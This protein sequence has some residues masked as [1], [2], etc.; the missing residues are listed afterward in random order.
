MTDDSTSERAPSEGDGRPSH[1]ELRD[2]FVAMT[3]SEEFTE[4]QHQRAGSRRLVDEE[5]MSVSEAVTAI[6]KADGLRDTYADPVYETEG[7]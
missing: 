4:T 3:E 1:R 5:S 6:V 2:I 7:N